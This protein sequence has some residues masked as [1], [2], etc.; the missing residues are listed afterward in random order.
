MAGELLDDP[1]RQAVGVEPAWVEGTGGGSGSEPAPE[2]TDLQFDPAEYTVAEIEE[3]LE[4]HPEERDA[5][6]AA[7]R[8]GK[9][10]ASLTGGS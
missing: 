3:Y 5:V 7:E 8:K 9:N 10:R 2:P 4:D 1:N 6:I